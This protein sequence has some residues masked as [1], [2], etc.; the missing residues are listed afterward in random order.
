MTEEE[1]E[2]EAGGV[3]FLFLSAAIK[4]RAL[5]MLDK[6]SLWSLCLGLEM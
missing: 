4:T 5:Y 3:L 2:E 6:P 1:G